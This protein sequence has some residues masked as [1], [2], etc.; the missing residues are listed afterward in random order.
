M[1]LAWTEVPLRWVIF[2]DELIFNLPIADKKTMKLVAGALMNNCFHKT[3][4]KIR[5]RLLLD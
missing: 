1:R 4:D 2:R 5:R 3:H